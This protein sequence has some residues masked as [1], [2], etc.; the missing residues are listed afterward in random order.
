MKTILVLED[1]PANLH[2]FA[3]ILW[4]KGY[5]V[6]EAGG[7]PD[8]VDAAERQEPQV[9]LL[10]CDVGLKGDE[11]SGTDVAV[12]LSQGQGDLPVLFVSG[13]PVAQWNAHYRE[14]LKVLDRQCVGVLEKPFL[15]A[16]LESAVERLLH[17]TATPPSPVR[18]SRSPAHL[19]FVAT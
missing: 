11:L 13:N 10:V 7:S 15:P 18:P 19:P 2:I 4:S 1:D 9:D 5:K 16:D 14:N 8:A 6:L 12:A 3:A 17:K